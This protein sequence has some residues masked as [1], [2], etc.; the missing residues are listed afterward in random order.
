MADVFISYAREDQKVAQQLAGA[1]ESQGW[2]V[3]WDRTIPAGQTWRSFTGKAL[4]DASC[5][6]VAWSAAS[7]DS[8][9]V[10]EEA[11]EAKQRGILV[12][13][14]IQSVA[15]PFGFR[16]I[17]AADLIDW[18]GDAGA[19]SF[20]NL[21]DAASML[22][23]TPPILF[24]EQNKPQRTVAET[25]RKAEE[26][27]RQRAEAEPVVKG[28]NRNPPPDALE[29]P[30]ASSDFWGKTEDTVITPLDRLKGALA[31]AALGFVFG[32]IAVA[33]ATSEFDN[34]ATSLAYI[35]GL[36]L[37]F[38]GGVAGAI[39]GM[40]PRITLAAVIGA[41][42]AWVGVSFVYIF[43]DDSPPLGIFAT[44]GV[45]GAPVGAIIGAVFGVI[46]KM[47]RHRR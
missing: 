17:Q 26:E 46:G 20:I 12:P 23:G 27:Q 9:W 34:S 44:S 29:Q 42:V 8:D 7:I 30:V 4:E 24:E 31:G 22:L 41:G 35:F 2:S 28:Q 6:I 43:F 18:N 14:F 16:T 38:S 11:E 45:L 47:R 39:C 15:P 10:H 21:V 13:A 5:V 25:K 37:G 3:F 33:T 36:A 32:V 1:L 19:D 40:H